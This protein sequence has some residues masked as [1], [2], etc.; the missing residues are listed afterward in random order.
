M[1]KLFFE[2][3]NCYAATSGLTGR[4]YRADKQGF[5]HVSDSAD[6]KYLQQGGYL[7]AGGMPR[8]SK[9]WLCECGW[10]AAINSCPKCGS[11][12]LTKIER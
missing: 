8:L 7:V 10:E 6:A 11:T 4:E 1:T 12:E 9:Y 3:P 2:A 5:I